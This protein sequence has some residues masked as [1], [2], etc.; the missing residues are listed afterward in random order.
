MPGLANLRSSTGPMVLLAMLAFSGT[1]AAA[2]PDRFVDDEDGKL[3]LSEHLLE[4]KGMLPVPIVITEPAV[5]YGGGLAGLFFDQPLGE[6]LQ[7]SMDE[8]GHPVPPNITGVAA[9]KTDNGSWGGGVGHRH[10]WKQDRYRYGGGIAKFNVNLDYYGLLGRANQYNLDGM[11]FFQQFLARA[12]ES[13]WLFGGRYAL[14]KLDARFGQG[15][16]EELGPQPQKDIGIGR[17]SL[18]ADSDTRNN[19]F[20]PTR[21]HFIEA[22]LVKASPKLGG[23]SSYQQFNLRGFNWQPFGKELVLGLRGDLQTSGGDIPFF[24]QPFINLRG[25]QAARYQNENAAV[26]E[27]ELWWMFNPRWSVLGFA[28]GGRAWGR[29]V[30][31]GDAESIS[32]G[33]VGFRYLIARKLG[34]HAGLDVASGPDGNIFYIQVGSPWR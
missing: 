7:T 22:E 28:G 18:V 30:D 17:L 25:V 14:L 16:P 15:W 26:L 34:I 19:I 23:N 24:A 1:Q 5:G 9:F 6:A 33:G 31:F 11:I 8:S 13:S 2:L 4:H 20:S 10:T 29:R 21:G 12:G 32:A 27:A 3:D